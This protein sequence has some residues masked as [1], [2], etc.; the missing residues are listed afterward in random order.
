[1]EAPAEMRASFFGYPA[2]ILSK[3]FI[4]RGFLIDNKIEL[5]KNVKILYKSV[6]YGKSYFTKRNG[7]YK[8]ASEKC[9]LRR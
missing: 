4:L 6:C 3:I 7:W 5:S 9:L 2:T 8:R 1:M